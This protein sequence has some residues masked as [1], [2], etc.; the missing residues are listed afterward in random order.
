[1]IDYLI[2]IVYHAKDKSDVRLLLQL[3]VDERA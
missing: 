3:S 2:P 1:M